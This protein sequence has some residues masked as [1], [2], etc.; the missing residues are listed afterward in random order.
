MGEKI[1]IISMNCQGLGGKDK[2]K[3]VLNYLKQRKYSI[4][5]LQDTHFTEKEENYIRTQWGYDCYFSSH[6]S[7]SRGTAIFLNNNFEFKLNKIKRD[8]NGNK[9]ILDLILAGKK[10]TLINIYGP[11]RDRPTFFEQIQQDIR[12]FNTEYTIITGD[13]NLILDKEKD[14]KQYLNINNPRSREKVLDICATFN[15]IDIWR[16]LHMEKN[17]FTWRAGNSNKQARLDFFL[18][19]ENLFRDI[20]TAE[21]EPGYR[22]DHSL[23]KLT[24]KISNEDKGRSFW[25]FNSSLLK[26]PEY[27]KSIKKVIAEVKEQYIDND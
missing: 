17:Q 8:M 16:E 6:N 18:I 7:Q 24:I 2:R 12:D 4:Y 13:F 20:E 10:I 26:D 11:N 23:I 25:K 14:S 5:C 21:I 15:L 22:T 3:D 19:S 1:T 9:I 27:V